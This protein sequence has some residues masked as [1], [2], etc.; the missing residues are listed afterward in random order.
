MKE[1]LPS[2]S[3]VRATK[4]FLRLWDSSELSTKRKYGTVFV[5]AAWTKFTSVA[6]MTHPFGYNIEQHLQVWV[7]ISVSGWPATKAGSKEYPDQWQCGPKTTQRPASHSPKSSWWSPR[8]LGKY[9]E[10]WKKR[11]N[12]FDGTIRSTC[13]K[14]KMYN[15]IQREVKTEEIFKGVNTSCSWSTT[16]KNINNFCVGVS[17]TLV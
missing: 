13:S 17:V 4:T 1:S 3:L 16:I 9:C 10:Y 15:S 12:F 11:R 5:V 6:T 14:R 8:R 2:I 7:T